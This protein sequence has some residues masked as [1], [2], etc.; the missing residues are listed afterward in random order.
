MRESESK[1]LTRV[2]SESRLFVRTGEPGFVG[3]AVAIPFPADTGMD[4]DDDVI[5][6]LPVLSRLSFMPRQ[7]CAES[8]RTGDCFV[9]IDGGPDVW[10][11]LVRLPV[12][13][14]RLLLDGGP[15]GFFTPLMGGFGAT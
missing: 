10:L 7:L 8:D 13:L 6:R 2:V 14:L 12:L 3:D 5:G 15:D 4:D 1:F 11:R 9:E